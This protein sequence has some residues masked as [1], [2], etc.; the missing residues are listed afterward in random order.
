MTDIIKY[1]TRRELL[2]A[3][4]RLLKSIRE[5]LIN[6]GSSRSIAVFEQLYYSIAIKRTSILDV[7]LEDLGVIITSKS[8]SN[9]KENEY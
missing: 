7:P 1:F 9:S 6:T 5:L 3:T 4:I 8:E 2:S